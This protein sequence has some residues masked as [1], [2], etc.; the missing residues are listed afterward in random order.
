MRNLLL[1]LLISLFATACSPTPQKAALS[2]T[3]WGAVMIVDIDST[4]NITSLERPS[5]TFANAT[6]FNGQTPCNA[7]AG[8]YITSADG[9]IDVSTETTTMAMCPDI[10]FEAAFM[11]G[12][13]DIAFFSVEQDTLK[14]KDDEGRVI[15]KFASIK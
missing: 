12:L 1:T 14:L 13:E 9:R 11:R 4:I 8:T 2:G 6:E 7:I 10:T 5:I 15:I 3:S